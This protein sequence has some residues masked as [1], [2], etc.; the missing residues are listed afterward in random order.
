MI[1]IV[2]VIVFSGRRR[3]L[4]RRLGVRVWEGVKGKRVAREF[5]DEGRVASWEWEGRTSSEYGAA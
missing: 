1:R 2:G 3:S 5:T 4:S